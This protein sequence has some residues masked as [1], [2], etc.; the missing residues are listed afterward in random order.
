M[1]HF[2][3]TNICCRSTPSSQPAAGSTNTETSSVMCFTATINGEVFISLIIAFTVLSHLLSHL[4]WFK[5]TFLGTKFKGVLRPF[6]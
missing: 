1:D 3:S 6:A 5:N 4:G 2:N